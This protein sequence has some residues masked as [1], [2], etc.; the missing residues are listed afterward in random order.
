MSRVINDSQSPG[1]LVIYFL[2]IYRMLMYKNE[3]SSMYICTKYQIRS[4]IY[5]CNSSINHSIVTSHVICYLVHLWNSVPISDGHHYL[6]P[7]SI[8]L[9]DLKLHFDSCVIRFGLSFTDTSP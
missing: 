6:V 9:T 1:H 2:D 7:L 3:L 5:T 8:T 4:A